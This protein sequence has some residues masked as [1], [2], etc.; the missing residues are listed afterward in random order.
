MISA[1]IYTDPDGETHFDAV[2][3]V[4]KRR[5]SPVSSAIVELSEALR[6]AEARFRRVLVD[7]P[8][9]PHPAPRRQLVVHLRGEVEVEVSDGEVRRFGPG[10]V[11]LVEDLDGRGHLTRSVGEEP[12]ETLMLALDGDERD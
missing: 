4:T 12:R 3:L 10:S 8:A 6:I 2:P 5:Q 7:H 1:R 9:E 11:V